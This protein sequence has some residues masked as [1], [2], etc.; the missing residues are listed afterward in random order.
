MHTIFQ[1]SDY[2]IA[3]KVEAILNKNSVIFKKQTNTP[4]RPAMNSSTITFSTDEKY[5]NLA[6]KLLNNF[7]SELIISH[8]ESSSSYYNIAILALIGIIM[9]WS[10]IRKI[11]TEY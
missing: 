1:T 9:V 6:N 8:Q 4:V 11:L 10:V 7:E 2:K 5:I 3:A